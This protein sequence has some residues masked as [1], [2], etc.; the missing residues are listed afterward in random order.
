[1]K[2]SEKFDIFYQ[3]HFVAHLLRDQ[4]FAVQ[5]LAD[6]DPELFTD[7]T[8]RLAT[9]IGKEFYQDNGAVPDFLFLSHIASL[10]D[11][12]LLPERLY[13]SLVGLWNELA[14][15]ALS[16]RQYLLDE[17][18]R[19]LKHMKYMTLLPSVID[20]V[21]AGRIE[22]ADELLNELI[23]FRPSSA[24]NLGRFYNADMVSRLDR[25]SHDSEQRLWTLI[26][27]IDKCLRGLLRG[28]L[29]VWQSQRSSIGKSAALGFLAR[30]FLLQGY[31]VLLITLEMSEDMYEDRLDQTIGG[32][33][34]DGL[35]DTDRIASRI[36]SLLSRGGKC[37][38]KHF[39]MYSATVDD[40]A[41]FTERLE[42]VH[43]FRPD[44]IL[45]DYADLLRP[46]SAGAKNG[47]TYEA[48][49]DVYANLVGW[50]QREQFACWTAMQSGRGAMLETTADQQHAGESIA[51]MQIADIVL[52]INRSKEE[53]E[54]GLTRIHVVKARND[55]AR[56]D[57]VFPTELERMQFWSPRDMVE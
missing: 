7:D 31:N 41:R 18:D 42:A 9:T 22:E 24:N 37:V 44:A 23:T 53:E 52:S 39:P 5:V 19:F 48:G 14:S 2:L 43:N 17:Y 51:K 35:E 47:S 57:I 6:F 21:Q 25:R 34:S 13:A 3:K 29:G 30:S 46:S 55:K 40:L 10:R 50:I 36:R 56:Y 11:Q 26:P 45:L 32:V 20:V 12:K 28:E 27:P 15:L 49:K 4:Y 16:N 8:L 54:Q 38:I 1:M 33:R